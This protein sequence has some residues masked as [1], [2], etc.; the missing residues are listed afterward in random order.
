MGQPKL[1]QILIDFNLITDEQ[2]QEALRVHENSNKRIGEILIDLGYITESQLV[3]VLE[4]QLGVPHVDLSKYDLDQRLTRYI[5]E[6][7]ARRHRVIPLIK[8]DNVLKVAM[9]DPLDIFAIDDI[10]L[11]AKCKIETM[12]AS[13]SDIESGIDELYSMA[14][15]G[16]GDFDIYAAGSGQDM[17]VD[18][19][20]RLV[21]DAPIVRLTNLLIR[22]AIQQRA[23]DIHIEPLPDEIRVRYRID[24][25]LHETRT[26]P[27]ENQAALIS[28]LKIMADLDIAERRKPQDG[29]IEIRQP[30]GDVDIRVAS[31]PTIYGEKIVLRILKR[32]SV[33]LDIDNL[34]F[35]PENKVTFEE[36]LNKPHGIIFVTGPT[37]SGKT[38]TLFTALNKLNDIDRNISTVEDPVEYRLEGINQI[39]IN[40]KVGMTFANALRAILRQDP[41][42]IMVGEIRDQETASIAVRAALTGHLVLSTIHTNDAASV[43]TRLVDMGIEPYLVSSSII[44][45]VGQRLVRK[46]CP[47]CKERIEPTPEM[48]RY[49]GK[50]ASQVDYLYQGKGCSQCHGTGYKGQMAIHEILTPDAELRSMVTENRP[51]EKLK[52]KAI[53][54]GMKTMKMDGIEKALQG[55]TSLSEVMRVAM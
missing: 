53:T 48:S 54:S 38:T 33:L 51:A 32:D 42:I 46:L 1:G 28:R 37:G 11:N 2:F 18:E 4:F 45:V 26:I 15:L 55:L 17:E 7:V 43:I 34:G 40:P 8:E 27:K 19:L 29:R 36:M 13:V 52:A 47:D 41:N 35:L 21:E 44:G 22:Q 12:I 3:Q 9:V 14:G 25:V 30:E 23:S 24:G 20:R 5:P 39:Q 10:K 50:Y 31:I 6:D 49:L 16:N